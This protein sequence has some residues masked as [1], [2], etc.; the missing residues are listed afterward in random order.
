MTRFLSLFFL[1]AALLGLAYTGHGGLMEMEWLNYRVRTSVA[2][3]LALLISSLVIVEAIM[4]CLAW[5]VG[6]PKAIKKKLQDGRYE[7]GLMCLNQAFLGIFAGEPD[8]ALK[9]ANKAYSRIGAIGSVKLIQAHAYRLAGKMDEARRVFGE[10]LDSSETRLAG[11]RGL[12]MLDTRAGR[13]AESASLIER[14]ADISGNFEWIVSIKTKLYLAQQNWPKALEIL[15]EANGRG[16]V[17]LD[18][19]RHL[20]LVYCILA[21]QALQH[22]D[23]IK[24]LDLMK[25]SY[26]F[27]PSELGI[28]LVYSEILYINDKKNKAFFLLQELYSYAPHFSIAKKYVDFCLGFKDALSRAEKLLSLQPNHPISHFAVARCAVKL[29]NYKYAEVHAQ[30]AKEK[31]PNPG[32]FLLLAEVKL[33][34]SKNLNDAKSLLRQALESPYDASWHCMSCG[35]YHKFWSPLCSGC[36]DID[37]V[38]WFESSA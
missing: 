23:R 30:R 15:E 31:M 24:A 3:C 4:Q 38:F 25:K 34:T 21:R 26:K 20:G 36:G 5:L 2:F 17:S 33:F 28:V 13:I 37:K 16:V 29:N 1:I 7:C 12:I 19:K 9:F 14:A 10:I 18:I 6:L 32:V 11:M 22:Q 35:A 27:L 8:E